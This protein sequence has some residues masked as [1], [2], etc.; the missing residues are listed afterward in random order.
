MNFGLSG[1]PIHYHENPTMKMGSL[2]VLCNK[3][4]F[5]SRRATTD[6]LLVSCKRCTTKLKEKVGYEKIRV[7]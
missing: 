2:R 4:I 3:V 6:V 1:L 7:R 5:D